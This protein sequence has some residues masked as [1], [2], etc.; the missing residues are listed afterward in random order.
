MAAVNDA[1]RLSRLHD[2]I[3][4]ACGPKILNAVYNEN[5]IEIML[6]PDGTIWIEEYGKDQECIGYLH[7]NEYQRISDS[8]NILSLV[9]TALDQMVSEI[10]PVVEGTFPLDNSRFEGTYP[11]LV[12]PCASF[13]MRKPANRIITL[14]EYIGFGAI[15]P[16]VKEIIRAAIL[17][18]KNILVVG[19]T[20]S[21]KT[22][23]CNGIIRYMDELTPN[24][25]ILIMEDTKELQSKSANL[26]QFLSSAKAEVGFRELTKVCM[27]YAPKRI[28]VGE[29]RDGS[30]L[31]MLKL[32]NTGHPGGIGTLHADSAIDALERLEELVEE[33]GVGPKPGLIGRAIDLILF[34]TKLPDNTRALKE[35]VRVNRYNRKAQ[36]YETEYVYRREA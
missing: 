5:V 26:V 31:E 3:K 17:E 24:D 15:T 13:S 14:D 28:H 35:I 8:K 2:S 36:E 7:D 10:N 29:V 25:R 21:G 34:M 12:G 6:N 22:T 9:G 1:E 20:S 30:S 27:R 32:W 19:G 18:R 23:F 11:P 16:E 4:N 33:A